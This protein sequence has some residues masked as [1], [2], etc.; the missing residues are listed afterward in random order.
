MIVNPRVFHPGC[1][2]GFQKKNKTLAGFRDTI[3]RDGSWSQAEEE[4]LAVSCSPGYCGGG[5]KKETVKV[6]D[7]SMG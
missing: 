4:L 3:T 2:E 7:F 6:G 1:F 5:A